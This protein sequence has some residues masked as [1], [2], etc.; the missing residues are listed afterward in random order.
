MRPHELAA[1]QAL[2]PVRF[3]YK[4]EY[5]GGGRE[6]QYGLIAEE[7]AET[8]PDLVV[9]DEAGAPWTVR[10]HLLAPLLLADA[11]RLERERAAL[12]ARVQESRD[13]RRPAWRHPRDA[14]GA[15]RRAREHDAP[16]LAS[17]AAAAGVSSGV[18][19]GVGFGDGFGRR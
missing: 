12:A 4:P 16:P 14:G 13:G 3:V 11:Q 1:L 6:L 9:R 10:Y 7:V 2:R 18:T 15:D 5:S 17:P 8:L 19:A